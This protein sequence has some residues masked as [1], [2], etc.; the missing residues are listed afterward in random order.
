M[1][2]AVCI[3]QVPDSGSI[4]IDPEKHTLVRGSSGV[5]INPLD[6][7]PV[8]IAL[9]FKDEIGAEVSVFT[10]GPPRAEEVLARAMAMGAD[11]GFLL[12]DSI[13]INYQKYLINYIPMIQ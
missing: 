1:R 9:R 6:E 7:F 3:K 8:E 5:A 2:I 4:S 10:M 13:L 12:S 11:K